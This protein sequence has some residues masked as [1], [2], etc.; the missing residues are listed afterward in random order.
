VAEA[1]REVF[2]PGPVPRLLRFLSWAVLAACVVMTFVGGWRVGV[3]EDEPYHV[4]RFDNY[5]Q[6]GWYL[7][8]GQLDHGHPSAG[9]T[10]QY[11]YGPAATLVLHGVNALV[12]VEPWGHAG[13]SA[14]A[15]AVRHLSVGVFGLLGL[16]A[17]VLTGRVLFWRWDWGVL[18]GAL[19]A[20][21]PLWT[22]HAMFNVKDVPV[23]TGYARATMG[24][25][26]LARERMAARWWVRWGGPVTLAAGL[27]LA[28]GTRP[29]MWSGIAFGAVVLLLFRGLRREPARLVDRVRADLWVL[30]DLVV[31]ALASWLLLWWMDPK[32]F[33]SPLL[34][35][36]KSVHSSATFKGR[37][38]PWHTV[39]DLIALQAP[40]VLLVFFLMGSGIVVL[41][42][43][44]S[45]GRLSATETRYLI[46]GSQAVAMPIGA[47]VASSPI[48]G[49]LRQ[50]IFSVP[51]S[52][53]IATVALVQVCESSGRARSGRAFGLPLVISASILVPVISQAMLFPYNYA[54]YNPLQSLTGVH[55]NGEYLRGSAIELVADVPPSGR[56][57]C[58]PETDRMAP[59]R[60]ADA[61]RRG[62][63]NGWTDCRTDL[64]SPIS[65][66]ASK[67]AG[68]PEQ[69]DQDAF[70]AISFNP[71]GLV[72][73]N[74]SRAAEVSRR[75]LWQHLHMAT[76]S[77]CRLAFPTMPMGT[78]AFTTVKS[79]ADLLP[80]E[81]WHLPGFDQTLRGLLTV[82]HRSTMTFRLPAQLR[83]SAIDLEIR[84]AEPANPE[85][86]FGGVHLAVGSSSDPTTLVVEIPRDLVDRS[87]AEP[88]S[89]V[90]ASRSSA[91][92]EM[93][94][95][96]LSVQPTKEALGG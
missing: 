7:A 21:V 64:L 12:G 37:S 47:M 85:I 46:V 73:K 30:W 10:Q 4:Q 6:T 91:P 19:M 56:L 18:A 25:V 28:V 27:V 43:V 95:L 16:V 61:T 86:T 48:Y 62:H 74:C 55:T 34:L 72:P 60:M 76:L 49:D 57:V 29:A 24:L 70:W 58:I 93:K 17:V 9:M 11:V 5:L 38:S 8:D 42:V 45:R 41:R 51:A 39:A 2:T 88:L 71:A 87:I 78:V 83:G 52:A 94:V 68:R 75:T 22:G 20:A 82:G 15:Y 31:A 65:P 50:L 67:L 32:V 92:L 80:D 69:L 3:T 89:L 84:T 63:L 23:A 59:V 81:G 53:L 35:L 79:A 13:T 40:L 90:F 96:S 33:S 14:H 77:L 36:Y 66:Y 54:F 26:L 1:G 44:A